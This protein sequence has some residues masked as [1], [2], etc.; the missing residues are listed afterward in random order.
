MVKTNKL[1]CPNCELDLYMSE[2]NKKIDNAYYDVW[3]CKECAHIIVLNW[4][5]S[6]V[7]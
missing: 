3:E 1:I 4:R 5:D 2:K 6:D 7:K